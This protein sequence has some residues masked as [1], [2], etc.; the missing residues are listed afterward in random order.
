MSPRLSAALPLS[1]LAV[2]LSVPAA[3]P[4]AAVVEPQP[5]AFLSGSIKFPRKQGMTLQV[6][7]RAGS[8]ATVTLGFD[9]RCRGGGVGEFWA[10]FVPAHQTIRIRDGRFKAKLTG[11]TRDI[12]RIKGRTAALHWTLTGSFTAPDTA[13]ATV[14]GTAKL[15]SGGRVISRCTIAEPTTAKLKLGGAAGVA[16]RG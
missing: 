3:S 7:N 10:A 9:G 15:R 1:V 16:P 13:T 14:S 12:G 8:R 4:A 5:G 6:D 2:A 11:T